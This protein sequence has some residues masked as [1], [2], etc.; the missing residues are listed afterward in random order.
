MGFMYR[1]HGTNLYAHKANNGKLSFFHMQYYGVELLLQL[2]ITK[3]THNRRKKYVLISALVWFVST[4]THLK[5][6]SR[7]L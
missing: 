3:N 5:V 4:N 6:M 2:T 7:K 1:V